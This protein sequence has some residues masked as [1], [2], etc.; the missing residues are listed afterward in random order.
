MEN[1]N[2]RPLSFKKGVGYTLLF[3]VLFVF[4]AFL[5]SIGFGIYK[6]VDLF[7]LPLDSET[8]K[9]IILVY[10]KD[11]IYSISFYSYIAAFFS[12]GFVFFRK[13]ENKIV[14]FK[15]ILVSES[16]VPLRVW[17]AFVPIFFF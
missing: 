8:L 4:F 6:V 5:I 16:D 13:E 2:I 3:L 1:S 9:V 7:N 14:S 15:R 17:L 10:I 11:S 12:V